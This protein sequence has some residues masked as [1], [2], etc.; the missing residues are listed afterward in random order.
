MTISTKK[1]RLLHVAQGAVA[2]AIRDNYGDWPGLLRDIAGVETSK[3]LDYKGFLAVLGALEKLGF[4]P[5]PRP[6]NRYKFLDG[7]KYRAYVSSGEAALVECLWAEYRGRPDLPGLIKWVHK[8]FGPET[9]PML[10]KGTGAMA[11][12][13]LKKMTAREKAK[14]ERFAGEPA[15]VF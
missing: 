6:E 5:R 10:H 3:D 13:A 12:E 8:Y 2:D 9:F 1:I 4:V 7:E 11:I 14:V 15:E